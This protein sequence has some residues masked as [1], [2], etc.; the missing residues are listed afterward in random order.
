MDDPVEQTTTSMEGLKRKRSNEDWFWE[1]VQIKKTLKE[2][3][4]KLAEANEKIMIAEARAKQEMEEKSRNVV[5]IKTEEG[6]VSDD[7]AAVSGDKELKNEILG[8]E[9]VETKK[10]LKEAE[11]RANRAEARANRA[12]D[13]GKN[14]FQGQALGETKKKLE[15]ADDR[16][17]RAEDQVKKLKLAIEDLKAKKNVPSQAGGDEDEEISDDDDSVGKHCDPWTAKFKE[18]RE[19][20]MINGN[21]NVSKDGNNSKLGIWVMNQRAK[22]RD[23]K[24]S[25]ECISK[26]ES[27]GFSWGKKYPPQKSWEEMYRELEKYV[28]AMGHCNI[29][30][31]STSPSPLA[32]WVSWQRVEYKRLKHHKD[33]LLEY[34]QVEK[35]KKLGFKFKTQKASK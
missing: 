17:K 30:V 25:T 33:T 8:K 3:K 21:C 7:G 9:L 18:L 26:L 16:A 5:G 14:A 12:E 31:N 13:Q 24:I 34:E 29:H 11:D 23:K 6:N 32:K 27:I 35:L 2:T 1:C 28:K 4:K 22:Y 20:R 15:E 19:Y 10:K